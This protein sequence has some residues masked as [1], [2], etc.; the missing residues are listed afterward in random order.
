VLKLAD[1]ERETCPSPWD[2]LYNSC[3]KVKKLQHTTYMIKQKLP[4]E[5]EL[6]FLFLKFYLFYVYEDTGAV[7]RH[8]RREHH[9]LLQMVVSHHVVA[10]N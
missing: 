9:I 6:V 7:F 2:L 4:T 5:I 3:L 8:T 10:G 1:T